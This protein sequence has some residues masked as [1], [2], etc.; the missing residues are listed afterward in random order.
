MILVIGATGIVGFEVCQ[1]LAE[2][3]KP[4][5]AMV[6][7]T[8]AEEKVKSLNSMGIKTINGDLREPKTFP[9]AFKGVN[10]AIVTVSSMPFSYVANDNDIEKVD[11]DG[12]RHLIRG[13]KKAEVKRLIFISLSKNM[14]LD[15][16]LRNAKRATE[17]L[18]KSSGLDYTILRPSYFME[19]WLSPELGF[20]IEHSKAQIYGDGKMPVSYISYKDVARFA[21]ESITNIHAKNSTIELGGPQK[22]T[23]LDA[24]NIFESAIKKDFETEFVPIKVLEG[25]MTTA[26]DPMQKSISGLMLCLANGDP[27]DMKDTLK[28]FKVEMTTVNDYAKKFS[29]VVH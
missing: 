20:D 29:P 8:S 9:D 13:A 5:R 16:P 17:E 12:M 15:F 11:L 4:V 25:K 2:R 27:I 19:A 14:N 26:N 24:V 23:Q 22:I 21:I 28:K 18:L 1:Q 10:T 7:S 6:R 3:G